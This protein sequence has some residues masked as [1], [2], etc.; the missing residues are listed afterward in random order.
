MTA[1]L[2]EKYRMWMDLGRT[3]VESKRYIYGVRFRAVRGATI[4]TSRVVIA[5]LAYWRPSLP[6]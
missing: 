5:E 4:G 3:M 1:Y 6:G 2:G